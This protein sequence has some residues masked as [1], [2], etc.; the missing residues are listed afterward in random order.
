MTTLTQAHRPITALAVSCRSRLQ[1][2]T[3]VRHYAPEPP[4]VM[5]GSPGI[6]MEVRSGLP[7]G[8]SRIRTLGPPAK[9]AELGA[10]SAAAMQPETSQADARQQPSSF[11]GGHAFSDHTKKQESG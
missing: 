10:V 3:D 4:L 7:A 8:G 11:P 1:A 2:S 6:V 5:R 9:A